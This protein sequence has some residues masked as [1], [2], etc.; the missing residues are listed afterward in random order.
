MAYAISWSLSSLGPE[1]GTENY[2]QWQAQIRELYGKFAAN[3]QR[4]IDSGDEVTAAKLAELVSQYGECRQEYWQANSLTACYAS[5]QCDVEAY[6]QAESTMAAV[7]SAVEKADHQLDRLIGSFSSEEWASL[8]ADSLVDDVR[9]FL[10]RRRNE[11]GAR[12]P[13]QLSDFAAELNIDGLSA[14]SRLYDD[15]SSSVKITV[16]EKGELVQKSPGQVA[17]DGPDRSERENHFHATDKAWESIA[18]TAAAALNHIVGSR[19]TVDKYAGRESYLT[20]P[21]QQNRVSRKAI[22]AMW[23]AITAFTPQLVRYL[24][25][26]QRMLDLPEI[27]WFDLDCPLTRSAGKPDY[28]LACDV[29]HNAFH[30]F[31]DPLGQFADVALDGRW[32]EAENRVGKRQGGFCIDFPKSGETRIFM[33]YRDTEDSLSTLAHELGHSY[34]AWVL[35]NHPVVMQMY[36]MSL[37]ETASTFAETIVSAE[38]FESLTDREQKLEMLDRQITDAVGFLLNIHCRYL[39]ENDLY[40]Q[41]PNGELTP[42]QLNEMMVKAQK[43]AFQNA[44]SEEGYNPTFWISKLHFYISDEPFYNFPY[45]FG[46]LLS[47]RIFQEALQQPQGFPNRYDQFLISTGG[48]SALTAAREAFGFDLESEAFWNEALQPIRERV[49]RFCELAGV[50]PHE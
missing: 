34:H 37:A 7:L 40:Q 3:V 46:Y 13:D 28:Q 48:P 4:I 39:F 15:L 36:P 50:E 24:K 17:C 32:I 23:S 43:K 49:D 45:T 10:E 41:R 5:A 18:P 42:D 2:S 19:L 26:K 33:T 12:L 47:Q 14:W 25:T 38:R 21:M 11:A 27:C 30:K 6:R 9:G 16:M 44:L 29:I 22:D 8:M 1:P 31:H 20:I 35:R